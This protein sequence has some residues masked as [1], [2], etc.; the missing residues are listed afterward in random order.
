M[1]EKFDA[2]VEKLS[3]RFREGYKDPK[4]QGLLNEEETPLLLPEYHRRIPADGF[5]VYAEGVWDQIVSNKDLDLPTQQELLAQ[6]RCDEIAREV[7]LVFD[8]SITPLEVAQA[9][10]IKAGTPTL[11][12]KLGQLMTDARVNVLKNFEVE[13]SRYHK[14]VYARKREELQSNVDKRLKDLFTGQLQAAHKTG[15]KSFSDAVAAAVKLGQKKGAQYDFAEI[16]AD[17]KKKAYEG[18][19]NAA[20]AAAVEGTNF[21]DAAQEFALFRKELDQVSGQLRKEEMRRLATRVERWVR[22]RL[23]DSI[24]LEFNS[25]GSGRGGSGAPETGHKQDE[26]SEKAIWDCIWSLFTDTVEE[27]EKRFTERAKSYDASAEEVEI[28]LWRLR[29]KSWGVLKA[30]IDEETMEGNLLMKLRENFEDRFR[31]DENGVPR[32]WRPTD[33]I[34]GLFAK[35]RDHTLTLIPLLSK[36]RLAKTQAP[37]PLDAWI[38]HA[39][40]AVSTA[41]E[42]D[43]VPIGGVDEDEGKS[44]EEETTVLS[45]AKKADVDRRFRKTADGVYVEAKR[46]ALGGVTQT[47]W[48]MWGLLLVLGQNEIFAG[49]YRHTFAFHVTMMTRLTSSLVARNPFLILLLILLGTG[50]YVTYTLNLWGPII[51]MTTA[52]SEQGITIAKAKLREWLVETETGRQALAMSANTSAGRNI[53]EA[54]GLDRLDKQGKRVEEVE[55]EGEI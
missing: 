29:R 51:Q 15:I 22:S 12:P 5:S 36:F 16:V 10:D 38:G 50:A 19:R 39:P 14:G 3:T 46:G 8:E 9:R 52:A 30:K 21:S 28:G 41:D 48:W 40:A 42:E 17:E 45:D 43:N 44:L 13:A 23:G 54:V 24:G 2:A 31:Y 4:K 25:L 11:L 26:A 6:F 18:F 37:P 55:D 27:A 35:A 7:L 32:I 49:T 47:P 34:D 1:P 20:L 33:D 53:S